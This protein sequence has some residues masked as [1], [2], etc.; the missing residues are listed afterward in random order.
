MPPK[1]ST[2][3]WTRSQE[4]DG[5]LPAWTV[6]AV[7]GVLQA[8]ASTEWPCRAARTRSRSLIAGSGLRIVMLL[9]GRGFV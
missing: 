9:T 4:L 5:G 7:Y 8:S 3:T 6:R 1:G 2:R